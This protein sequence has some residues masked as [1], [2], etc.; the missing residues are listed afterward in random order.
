[1]HTQKQ[2]QHRVNVALRK[3]K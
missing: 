1:V 2:Q 3:V